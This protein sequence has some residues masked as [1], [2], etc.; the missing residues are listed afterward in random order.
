MDGLTVTIVGDI[1]HS[2][3]ARSNLHALGK[4]GAVVRV[5]GP[6]PHPR[7]STR[8]ARSSTTGSS[9]RSKEL[10]W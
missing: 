5:A 9:R 7:A 6:H 3:V 10:T 8:S 1:L 2:R 4:L